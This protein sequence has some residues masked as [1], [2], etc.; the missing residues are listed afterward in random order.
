MTRAPIRWG[1]GVGEHDH[2]DAP[3]DARHPEQRRGRPARPGFQ[4]A[5]GERVSG[6]VGLAAAGGEDR[7]PGG[8]A[9]Q[10]VPESGA[11]GHVVIS[12][13]RLDD[14]DRERLG[15]VDEREMGRGPDVLGQRPQ[16]GQGRFPHKRMHLP[17]QPQHSQAH[18]GPAADV[19]ADECVLLQG[20]Q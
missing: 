6:V 7:A 1:D 4:L 3:L 11:V 5:V 13:G 12:P 20:G 2:T 18:S 17:P 8:A 16:G 15:A 10:R 9:V 19:A 14:G